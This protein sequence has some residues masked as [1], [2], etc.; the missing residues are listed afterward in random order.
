MREITEGMFCSDCVKRE[1]PENAPHQLK[2]G[3]I[4]NGK[5]L[6]GNIIGE[7][8]FGITYIGRD[9]V[10]ETKVAIKEFYPMG[11]INRNNEISSNL[12]ISTE[13]QRDFIKKGR[14]RFLEEARNVAQ[15][16]SEP[17]I[18]NVKD[19]FE[20]NG[21]A[22][23]IMEY[24]EGKTLAAHI[25][26]CGPMDAGKVRELMLPLVTALSKIH[27]MGVIHRDISPDNIMYLGKGTCKLMDFGS[28]RYFMGK[29]QE[30]TSTVKRGY[31]P[32][33]QYTSTGN[34]GPWTDV[35][36]LCA[37]MY[38]CVTGVTP[39]D[40]VDRMA[41]DSLKWPSE[42]GVRISREF[43]EAIMR[44]LVLHAQGRCQNMDELRRLMEQAS[45]ET[46][47][48]VQTRDED[49]TMYADQTY[50]T[51]EPTGNT[52]NSYTHTTSTTDY[53]RPGMY[54]PN[55]GENKRGNS[56]GG[57]KKKFLVPAILG[58]AAVVAAAAFFIWNAG[59]KDSEEKVET[60][61]DYYVTG[62]EEMLKVRKAEE[63]DSKVVTKLENGE[64]VS[65]VERTADT[66][67]KVYVE[68]E[69]VTGYLD[70]HYLTDEK[71]GAMA[72]EDKYV[73]ISENSE[74]TILNTL[75]GNGTSVGVLERGDEITVLAAP[76]DTYAY[77]YAP[78]SKAFGYVK[79]D[80]LSDEK[81]EEVKTARAEDDGAVETAK[82]EKTDSV[83]SQ[84]VVGGTDGWE[85]DKGS[86]TPV[87]LDG[88]MI[89]ASSQLKADALASYEPEHMLDGSVNTCWS[90]GEG[91]NGIGTT[92][93]FSGSAK[94]VRGIAILPGNMK[95]REL[96]YR[97]SR[98]TRIKV[99]INGMAKEFD[100]TSFNPDFSDPMSSMLYMNFGETITADKVVVTILAVEE[101][102]LCQ[103]TCITEMRL[104][105]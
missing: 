67:W 65:L 49:A 46:T 30:L 51:Q 40:A 34:Q 103:D 105:G 90:E 64:K 95:S 78:E 7:G 20:E 97:N 43:E 39:V 52:T 91:G 100:L 44:G 14:E 4:L 37:T 77:I 16:S 57:G 21:T 25:K 54:D 11:R 60:I 70:H 28:A 102:N 23:I 1:M 50:F 18:V 48:T 74:V 101:G 82:N 26:E 79:Q 94:E 2:P 27:K 5:Y 84:N 13:E 3:T 83:P 86:S 98:P 53:G 62:R 6:V 33:E 32:T 35:Y 71:K 89:S 42:L 93:T 96:F 22:Y 19:F 69:D 29:D 24:L 36:G 41:Y 76:D 9:T 47:G 59:E 55:D 92:I 12:T 17:G 8:G 31:A 75:E 38:K 66:Y 88:Y 63:A 45:G 58:G 56:S 73:D 61:G 104:Y 72:P 99:S 85:S 15:F 80:K 87:F 10:L 81:P 68:A